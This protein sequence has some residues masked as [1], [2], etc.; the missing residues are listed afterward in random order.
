VTRRHVC[1]GCAHFVA[2]AAELEYEVPGLKILS[3]AFGSVRA[4][5]GLCRQ[6]DFFCV[7]EHGCAD[8]RAAATVPP[9]A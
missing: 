7:P 3:S 9:A 5:T 4:N 6:H 8:W 1:G 2:A